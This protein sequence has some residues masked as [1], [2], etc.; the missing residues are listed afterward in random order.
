MGIL[1]V[2]SKPKNV[3]VPRLDLELTTGCDHGC[4]HCY[5]VWGAKDSD[6]QGGYKKGSLRTDD[7]LKM[8]EKVVGQTGAEHITVTGGEPLLHKGALE[9]IDRAC[10]LVKSV[11]LITNGS[12][13]TPEI[14]HRFKKAGLRSVQL[15][16]L[17][18]KRARH[19]MLKGS[20]CFDD[21]V[22]A[23]L[24]LKD[25]GVPVQV[26]F[27]A[28][29]KNWEEF[30]DVFE[31]AYVLGVRAI[32][33][34][35]M[36]PTGGA[37]HHINQLLPTVEQVEHNLMTA[38][39]LGP[40]Y[41]IRVSTAMPIPPCLIRMDRFKW[42]DFGFC[43]TGTHSPNIVVDPSGNIRSCNLSSGI[44]GNMVEED[45]PQIYERVRT[46]QDAFKREVPEVC[47]GC[48]YETTCQGGCKESAFATF[49]STTHPEPFLYQT[50]NPG[51]P[52]A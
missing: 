44:L 4:G 27:V 45:W 23:A 35:R 33:Y 2:F 52:S 1:D 49:G 13:I 24:D 7:Y 39:R 22:R 41:S 6:P 12:H 20:V 9:I 36:S 29:Q 46:Y 28:M 31:L 38:E 21:T 18:A 40:Q 26:C 11:Q 48:R 15:T 34:N 10:V 8:L 17:S 43:S 5:N 25:A 3:T 42:F 14:A 16:L 51:W 19:D 37:V 47:R 30:E 32:S 50:Q